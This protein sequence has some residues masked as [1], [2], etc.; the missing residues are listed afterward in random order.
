MLRELKRINDR[1]NALL[2]HQ[3]QQL[4]K[5]NK[6]LTD[7]IDKKLIDIRLVHDEKQALLTEN[8]AL[9]N[10]IQNMRFM[11]QDKDSYITRL[12]FIMERDRNDKAKIMSN[13]IN[14]RIATSKVEVMQPKPTPKP[15]KNQWEPIV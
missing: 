8:F 13:E 1:D 12:Q 14:E 6:D 3:N 15:Q 2:R 5:E 7:D 11:L 4:I 9:Q 10:E